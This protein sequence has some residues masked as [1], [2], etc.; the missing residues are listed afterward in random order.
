MGVSYHTRR[1]SFIT[2]IMD[3]VFWI[4]RNLHLH[5]QSQ[6]VSC[7]YIPANTRACEIGLVKTLSSTLSLF[8]LAWHSSV[9]LSKIMFSDF[10]DNDEPASN[11]R[12]VALKMNAFIQNVVYRKEQAL[13][14]DLC[15]AEYIGKCA[16][17]I[18][19]YQLF[20]GTK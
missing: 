16:T 20:L 5:A 18:C 12:L 19:P 11:I 13:V 14:I 17:M 3:I 7:P 1:N 4:N 9:Y 10:K 2:G 15:R 6:I 8:V